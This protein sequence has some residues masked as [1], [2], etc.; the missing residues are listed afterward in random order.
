MCLSCSAFDKFAEHHERE[1]Q[2]SGLCMLVQYRLRDLEL[3]F[4]PVWVRQEG[5]C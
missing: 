3:I 4:V 5:A 1:L 2:E